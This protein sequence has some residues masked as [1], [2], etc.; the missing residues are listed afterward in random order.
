MQPVFCTRHWF[1]CFKIKLSGEKICVL[2]PRTWAFRNDAFCF[3]WNGFKP[4]LFPPFALVGCSLNKMLDD[5]VHRALL[6]VPHWVSQPWFPMLLSMIVS[7]PVRIPRHKDVLVLPH[8]CQLHPLE[9]RLSLVALVVSGIP[10]EAVGFQTR[11]ST[12]SV[13]HGEKGQRNSTVWHGRSGVF[14][15]FRGN[16]TPFVCDLLSKL[17]KT[18]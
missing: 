10:S 5:Q 13:H 8:N 18:R 7:L 11:L 1:V 9:G 15:V 14:G 12:L 17:D 6:A 4:Y 3:S 16:I 2:V